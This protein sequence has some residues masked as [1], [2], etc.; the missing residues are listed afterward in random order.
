MINSN[1]IKG[2]NKMTQ[3]VTIK[4]TRDVA[5]LINLE[6]ELREC[7]FQKVGAV[8]TVKK[9]DLNA[10][11]KTVRYIVARINLTSKFLGHKCSEIKEY[12]T[13]IDI[14]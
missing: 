13:F 4:I 2:T 5:H 12:S 8:L 7:G 14:V 9:S 1:E 6:N 11:I 3:T 10:D